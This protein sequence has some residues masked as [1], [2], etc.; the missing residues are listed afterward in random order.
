MC[1][2]VF[3]CVGMVVCLPAKGPVS[4]RARLCWDSQLLHGAVPGRAVGFVHVYLQPVCV[5]ACV[6]VSVCVCASARMYKAGC[7]SSRV[8][9]LMIYSSALTLIC[10]GLVATTT[11][12]QHLTYKKIG[13][14]VSLSSPTQLHSDLTLRILGNW[15]SSSSNLFNS[16]V[17]KDQILE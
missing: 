17:N 8:G 10:S 16:L 9:S 1:L 14:D 5:G 15:S 13:S 4:G 2:C 6:C 11:Y 7:W 12:M 3:V